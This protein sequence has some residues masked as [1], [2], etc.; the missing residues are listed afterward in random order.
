MDNY[1]QV[2]EEHQGKLL[3]LEAVFCKLETRMFGADFLYSVDTN[4]S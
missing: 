2:G 3:L 1:N 4:I